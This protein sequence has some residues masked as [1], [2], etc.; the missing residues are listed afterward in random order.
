MGSVGY[1]MLSDPRGLAPEAFDPSGANPMRTSLGARRREGYGTPP[2]DVGAIDRCDKRPY[3]KCQQ[4]PD[5]IPTVSGMPQAIGLY[6]ERADRSGP[7]F[8]LICRSDLSI[9]SQGEGRNEA[10]ASVSDMA[11]EEAP[12]RGGCVVVM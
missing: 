1:G 12:C 8:S 5:P 3:A 9:A 2:R 10:P 7:P 6:H 4:G 11:S